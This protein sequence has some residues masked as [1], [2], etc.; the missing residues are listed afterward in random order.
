VS[1][2]LVRSGRDGERADFA[3]DHE[4]ATVG[5]SLI[6]DLSAVNSREELR[7]L[8]DKH[9]SSE[10]SSRLANWTGQLWRFSKE[11]KDGDFIAMPLKRSPAIIFGVVTGPYKYHTDFPEN[12]EHTHAVSWMIDIPRSAIDSD[13]RYS[14]GFIGTVAKITRNNA[15]MRVHKLIQDWIDGS[16]KMEPTDD[17]EEV[18]EA[19]QINIAEI[20]RDAIRN[21]LSTRFVGHD[22][23]RLVEAVM[24]AQGYKTRLSPPGADHGVDILAGSGPYG[25]DSPKL[26]V[27]VKSGD[28]KADVKVLRE[29]NGVIERYKADG[30][31]LVSF[32]GFKGSIPAEAHH[33]HF[34]VRLWSGDDLIDAITTNY[35]R[36]PPEIKAEIPLKIVWTVATE[37]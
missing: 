19:D 9:Y 7:G 15:E 8:F 20:G 4:V 23:A 24:K 12:S 13:I 22:L 30:G 37:N 28:I 14:L 34:K 27:Q 5:W 11:I 2:W 1:L 25:I 26:C 21:L 36:M 33:E 10:P 17:H 18:A 16:A 29:L 31:L 35:D 6:P 3:L 32:G